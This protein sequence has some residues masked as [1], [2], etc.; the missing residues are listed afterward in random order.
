MNSLLYLSLFLV[1]SCPTKAQDNIQKIFL[2]LPD[3]IFTHQS[4]AGFVENDSFPLMERKRILG[5]YDSIYKYASDYP[6]FDLIH[7]NDTNQTISMGNGVHTLS[8]KY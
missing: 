8:I 4:H 7:V 3:T 2:E 6:I 1:L 5:D